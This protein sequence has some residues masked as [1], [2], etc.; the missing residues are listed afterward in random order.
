MGSERLDRMRPGGF[1][2]HGRT[3]ILFAEGGSD[4]PR[5]VTW[6]FVVDKKHSP[7]FDLVAV[8]VPVRRSEL[9]IIGKVYRRDDVQQS[10]RSHHSY[11]GETNRS[12]T[13]HKK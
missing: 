11:E 8:L 9:N 7:T 5:S 3:S 13:L 1:P 4:R 12:K 10:R 2:G 6:R